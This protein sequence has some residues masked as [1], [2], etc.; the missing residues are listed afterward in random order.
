MTVKLLEQSKKVIAY[1]IDGR[2]AAE[3]RKR[4]QETYV[5]LDIT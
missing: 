2:L 4:V 1:E 3:L 5:D